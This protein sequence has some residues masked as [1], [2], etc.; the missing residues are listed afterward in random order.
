ML[1]MPSALFFWLCDL[2]AERML[3]GVQF[4][5]FSLSG[6]SQDCIGLVAVGPYQ[7]LVWVIGSV[8]ILVR[9]SVWFLISTMIQNCYG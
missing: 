1:L 5:F 7:F 2:D 8:Y 3:A 4:L 6:F 9:R